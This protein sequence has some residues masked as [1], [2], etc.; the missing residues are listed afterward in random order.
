MACGDIGMAGPLPVR[1]R[2][3]DQILGLFAHLEAQSPTLTAQ[4]CAKLANLFIFRCGPGPRPDVDLGGKPCVHD[5]MIC[6]GDRQAR[7]RITPCWACTDW[8]FGTL[9]LIAEIVGVELPV[10]E[11]LTRG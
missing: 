10:Y 6:Q 11:E 8:A 9:E 1:P 4:Q 3:L 2:P 5:P 7:D